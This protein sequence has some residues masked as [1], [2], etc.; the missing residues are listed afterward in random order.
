[1]YNPFGK[2]LEQLEEEDLREKLHDKAESLIFEYKGP[3]KIDDR[4]GVAKSIASFANTHGGWLFV[5]IEADPDTNKPC[6]DNIAG[7]P[8]AKAHTESIYQSCSSQLSP[9]PYFGCYPVTLTNGNYV[10]VFSIPESAD[11]PHIHMRTGNVYVRTGNVSEPLEELRDRKELD[12]LYAKAKE[13]KRQ[14]EIL[15]QHHDTGNDLLKP[16][17]KMVSLHVHNGQHSI[18]D[19][20]HLALWYPAVMSYDLFPF[21]TDRSF[22]T[23]RPQEI[24]AFLQVVEPDRSS[25][26]FTQHGAYLT[27]AS[28]L[29]EYIVLYLDRFGHTAFAEYAQSPQA[30]G[31][32]VAGNRLCRFTQMCQTLYNDANYWGRV[33][34][35][36]KFGGLVSPS[37][38]LA[39]IKRTSSVGEMQDGDTE[40][41]RDEAQRVIGAWDE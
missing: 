39:T 8:P 26:Q 15:L 31:C 24:A 5:G 30:A 41:I 40:S 37:G 22:A 16:L 7:V 35:I 12:Q 38:I 17:S 36:C 21:V 23:N 27:L 9:T 34:L 28:S 14:I 32:A 2:P 29:Q 20:Y 33:E 1:M 3:A 13:T 6:L 19:A 18:L 10:L 4:A 25:I 11:P